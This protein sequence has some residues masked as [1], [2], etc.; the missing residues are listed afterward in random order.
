MATEGF[1][2]EAADQVA[3][4]RSNQRAHYSLFAAFLAFNILSVIGG[5]FLANRRR[6][7]DSRAA[8]Q[9]QHS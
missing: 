6:F 1:E 8:A 3:W 5:K 4:F 9:A 7:K 2:M